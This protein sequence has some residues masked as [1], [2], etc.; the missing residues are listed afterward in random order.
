MYKDINN[1]YK[2]LND[3]F[4]LIYIKINILWVL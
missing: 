4:F 1:D 2:Y 3:L